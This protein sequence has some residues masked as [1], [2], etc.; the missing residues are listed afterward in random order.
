MRTASILANPGTATATNQIWQKHST[1][2]ILFIT[3]LD[4]AFAFA[5]GSKSAG[6]SLGHPTEIKKIIQ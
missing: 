4:G 1:V 5:H 3:Y 2:Y 6:R